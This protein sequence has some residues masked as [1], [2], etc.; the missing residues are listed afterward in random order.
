VPSCT[1]S[2]VERGLPLDREVVR[3]TRSVGSPKAK[4]DV[5]ERY[6]HRMH[7][8]PASVNFDRAAEFYDETRDVGEDA[9]DQ[10]LDLLAGELTGRGRVLEIGVGTGIL[11]SPLTARGL[12]I[13][14]VDLSAAMLAKLLAKGSAPPP[15]LRADATRLPFRDGAFGAAY[16]RHVLHLIPDWRAA[17]AE[18]CRVV[19]RGVALLDAGAGGTAWRD[20]WGAM[21]A[22]TGPEADH[23]GLDL[24]RDGDEVLDAAFAVAGGVPRALPE[25]TYPETDTVADQLDEIERRSP[26]WTW[27]LSD[28]QLRAAL[29]AGRRWTLDR[30]DTLDVRLVESVTVRWRAYDL[31]SD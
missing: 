28:D 26:A 25:I 11:A 30:Y 27:R 14:G 19:G 9:T 5:A 10:T 4:I 6:P 16:G 15:V 23:I 13:V 7:E 3:T 21:R 2:I 29:E 31:G 20:L 8:I 12:D 17:V 22:V 1:S 18:L 24:K